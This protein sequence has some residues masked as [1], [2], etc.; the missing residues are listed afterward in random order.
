MDSTSKNLQIPVS[1][2]KVRYDNSVVMILL[3]YVFIFERDE[4]R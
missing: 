1:S 2:F 3:T 4:L